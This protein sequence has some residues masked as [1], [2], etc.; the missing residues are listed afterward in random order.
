MQIFVKTLTGKTITLDVE[1]SDTIEIVKE[2]IQDKEGVPPDKQTLIF[3]GKQLNDNKSLADYNIQ[4]ESTLHLQPI[5]ISCYCIIN[6]DNDKKLE[7]FFGC[8]GCNTTLSLKK[9]IK[10]ELGI[11]VEN[12]IL[13]KDGK[14]LLDSESCQ[15]N[16][17]ICGEEIQLKY[18]PNPNN[19]CFI[20]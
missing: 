3:A 9:T 4:R 18:I 19:K 7:I 13:I 1:P 10:K 6:Y 8:P 2:K 11:K 14:I 12:Q 20:F 16:N 5:R 15:S 17:I